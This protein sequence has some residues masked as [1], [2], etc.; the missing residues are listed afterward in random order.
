MFQKSTG[1]EFMECGHEILMNNGSCKV[2]RIDVIQNDAMVI[3]FKLFL[4]QY[5]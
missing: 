4:C 2:L 5:I 1:L 3:T